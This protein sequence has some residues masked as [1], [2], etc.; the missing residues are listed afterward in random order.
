MYIK[1]DLLYILYI[2]NSLYYIFV[3]VNNELDI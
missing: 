1:Y 2:I 3:C